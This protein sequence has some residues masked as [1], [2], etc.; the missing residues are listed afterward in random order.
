MSKVSVTSFPRIAANTFPG[1]I[2]VPFI[3]T[4]IIFPSDAAV[5]FSTSA[6]IASHPLICCSFR[7]G[8]AVIVILPVL[9]PDVGGARLSSGLS[10][11]D[12]FCNVSTYVGGYC[13]SLTSKTVIALGVTVKSPTKSCIFTL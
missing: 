6:M 2:D 9:P 11:D 10:E 3:S 8:V 7:Y 13:G 1:T 4:A 5:A 12:A